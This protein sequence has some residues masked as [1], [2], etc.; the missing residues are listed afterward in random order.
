MLTVVAT[1]AI[2]IAIVAAPVLLTARDSGP[3]SDASH[4][5]VA[6]GV[7]AKAGEIRT[8]PDVSAG[9]REQVATTIADTLDRLYT[10]AFSPTTD[11]TIATSPSPRP[12]PASRV[13]SF[14]TKD[15]RA[16][17]AAQPGVFEEGRDLVVYKGTVTFSGLATFEKGN[18]HEAFI[19]VDF[20]GDATP[21]GQTSPIIRVHQ[22]G[23]LTLVR[24]ASRW[25]VSGFN[26]RFAARPAPTPKPIPS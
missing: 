7:T 18:V 15:A 9:R 26:L 16:A 4:G 6:T 10:R 24:D 17:L 2:A 3:G 25:L 23:T 5:E 1:A 19:D 12:G 11:E 20:V 22:K 14:M 21:A 8:V 13:T